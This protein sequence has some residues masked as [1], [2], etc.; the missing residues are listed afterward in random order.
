MVSHKDYVLG[1]DD[2]ES[3]RLGVQHRLWSSAATAMWDRVG[4]QPGSRVLDVG[5]GPGW[6]SM[7]LAQLVGPSGR[8]LG[9]EGSPTYAEQF[10]R[11]ASQLD[12][13]HAS[14]VVG[15]VHDLASLVG[16]ELG[17][18]DIAYA[19]WV[20]SFLN[21]PAS[22]IAQIADALRPGGRL[23]VQDYFGYDAIRVAPRSDAFER[24]I[25]A[26]QAYWAGHGDLDVMQHVPAAMR[27]AGLEVIDLRVDQRVIRPG[28]AMWNWPDIFWPNFMPRVVEAGHLEQSELDAFMTAWA[29]A[30]SNPDAFMV[31][32]P[33]FEAIGK[34]V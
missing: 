11:R 24:G 18:F 14:V 32:P 33:V 31:L 16:D 8:V 34:K 1:T 17:T 27:A 23:A 28:D 22:V 30:S 7:D 26:I 20:M 3:R 2:A 13:P 25:A 21:D 10:R 4:I 5:C 15:D 12:Q 9:V 6:A 29:E 19:R